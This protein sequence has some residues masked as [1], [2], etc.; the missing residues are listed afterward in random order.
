MVRARRWTQAYEQRGRGPVPGQGSGAPRD[1]GRR[2]QGQSSGDVREARRSFQKEG[3][4]AV[5][6]APEKSN[7]MEAQK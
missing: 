2:I 6:G 3:Q 4:S 7:E 5:L 1:R